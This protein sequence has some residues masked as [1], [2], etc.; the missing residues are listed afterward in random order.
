MPS[1]LN[2]ITLRA[3]SSLLARLVLVPIEMARLLV[4]KLYESEPRAERSNV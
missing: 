3:M 2:S 1:I 4:F